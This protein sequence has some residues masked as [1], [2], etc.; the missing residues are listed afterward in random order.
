MNS[1]NKTS[2]TSM[3]GLSDIYSD[4]IISNNLTSDTVN[5]NVLVLGG[6][7]VT[8]TLNSIATYETDTNTT[9]SNIQSQLNNI[10]STTT[11][12]GGYFTVVCERL[13]HASGN[14]FGFGAGLYNNNEIV[15]PACTLIMSR[16]TS[17]QSLANGT[18]YYNFY[19][20]GVATSVSTGIYVSTSANTVTHN[21]TFASGDTFKIVTVNSGNYTTNTTVQLRINLIFQCAGIKGTDGITPTLTIGTVSTLPSSSNASVT[22][23][24]TSTNQILNFSIPQGIQGIQG[25]TSAF[26]IG[27]VVSLA[28]NATP[29][30]N[31]DS[32][33]TTTN[34]IFNF[35][36][37]Q[38]NTPTFSIGSVSSLASSDTPFVNFDSYSTLTNKIINFGLV[39]GEKG[40]K[41]DSIKGD[42]GD[43]G[44]SPGDIGNA[45]GTAVV[46]TTLQTQVGLIDTAVG[47]L[48]T[49]VNGLVA[50]VGEH[51]TL[52]GELTP[53]V[54]TLEGEMDTVNNKL[55]YVT[56]TADALQV[57]SKFQV[58]TNSVGLVG[59]IAMATFD[60][61]SNIITL[62]TTATTNSIIG[63][64]INMGSLS[65]ANT[66]LRGTSINIGNEN[67][68]TATT[69]ILG[70]TVN[71]G[72]TQTTTNNI[73]GR[74]INIGENNLSEKIDVEAPTINMGT[75]ITNSAINIGN[76]L[77][78]L[79]I[80]GSTINIAQDNGATVNLGTYDTNVNIEGH[81]V[82]IGYHTFGSTNTINM[83]A[84]TI[85][86]GTVGVAST[87]NIGN[88]L[89]YVNIQSLPNTSIGISNFI[90]QF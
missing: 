67:N 80:V 78:E 87:V 5:T 61:T 11:S 9:L 8:S 58:T 88:V 12:G 64:T 41:G 29:Y 57:T 75:S 48:T 86:I 79:D 89:S 44:I 19:K 7:D 43:A 63:N 71:N 49:T 65:T 24:G 76:S 60:P 54:T 20:N 69:N 84:S 28:Q 50:T 68:S 33:S 1:I 51:T 40:E 6:N 16:C 38:G 46:F 37:V 13:G 77:S 34:K 70:T 85:N 82:N 45:I 22:N 26:S 25:I 39:R 56:R 27:S 31:F 2:F 72:S 18:A 73:K 14:T 32:L 83:Q 10:T 81:N 3:N 62:G 30:V 47:G 23:T 55:L 66:I 90:S 74:T 4:D 52:I 53:R 17:S 15:L 36:L 42:K 21:L 59:N 35:G